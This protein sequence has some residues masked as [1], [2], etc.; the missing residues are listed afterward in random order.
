MK[1]LIFIFIF[2]IGSV[3]AQLRTKLLSGAASGGTWQ[4][5]IAPLGNTVA[6]LLIGDNPIIDW[7]NQPSGIYTFGYK[8]CSSSSFCLGCCKTTLTKFYNLDL[9]RFYA[10]TL[11]LCCSNE[12]EVLD[13]LDSF[14]IGM[15]ASYT[16][17]VLPMDTTLPLNQFTCINFTCDSI[18]SITL[19]INET[20]LAPFGFVMDSASAPPKTFSF[21]FNV[22]DDC[23]T[24][25]TLVICP[26]YKVKPDSTVVL[27]PPIE[28]TFT[29]LKND[30]TTVIADS[31]IVSNIDI[32]KLGRYC[33][34]I[35]EG[36]TVVYCIDLAYIFALQSN[37]ENII[38]EI[39]TSIFFVCLV[40][41]LILIMAVKWLERRI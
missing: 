21:G 25:T 30:S 17:T 13:L 38:Y 22:L 39:S 19:Q 34:Y 29:W 15:N 7:T 6:P 5:S 33:V 31:L 3:Q 32:P 27:Y 4:L 41:A 37:Y 40:I 35:D 11:D 8:V 14:Y 18:G 23:C 24:D 10:S 16:V 26:S 1:Y 36:C 9:G 28:G 20:P 12:Y 2:S